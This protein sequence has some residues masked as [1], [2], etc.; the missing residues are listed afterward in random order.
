LLDL[1][2]VLE[3]TR[4]VDVVFHLAGNSDI[5]LG[6]CRTDLDLQQGTMATHHLLEAMRREEVQRLIF[7]STSAVYGEVEKIPTS[8]DDGPLFPISL[9]G[10]SKLACEG[11]IS[12]FVHNYGLRAWIYRFCNV[13]GRNE[14]HGVI[15]DFIRKLKRDPIQLEILGDGKQA[16]PYLHV[17]DCV[18]GMIWGYENARDSLNYFNL[19]SH[20]VTSVDR[21]ADIVT[22]VMGIKGAK[23]IHAGGKRG[24]PGDVPQVRLDPAKLTTLG[25]TTLLTSDEA[26]KKAA[27]EIVEEFV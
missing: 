9:Y 6:R 10:A 5:R 8:E 16:K 1:D 21:I 22:E 23:Y 13:V 2:T 4:S 17:S 24:W 11:L 3:V 25:W 18:A 7:A 27:Q 19:S 12:A 15:V 26:V 20:G 14:T